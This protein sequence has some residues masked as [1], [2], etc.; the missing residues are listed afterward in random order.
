MKRK[1]KISFS[2]L[3]TNFNNGK[4]IKDAIQS[5]IDQIY[6]DWELIIVDDCSTDNSI[7]VIDQYSNNDKIKVIQHK[8]NLGYA[9]SLITAIE[10]ASNK[11][12]GILD[13][14]DKLHE[15]ALEIIYKIYQ[16]IPKYGFVYTKMWNCNSSL[17]PYNIPSWI[18]PVIPEKSD[19]F[20]H[21]ISHFRT[22]RKKDY[23][24]TSGFDPKQKKAVDQDIIYKLEEVTQF[25]FI[26]KSL[27]YYRHH[28]SG[29]SQGKSSFQARIYHYIAKCKAYKR[30]LN[31]NIPNVIL[32]D[33]YL[34][35]YK[36]TFHNMIKFLKYFYNFLKLNKKM[37]KISSFFLDFF[38]F[39]KFN[40]KKNLVK[41]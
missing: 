14:D 19:I 8:K 21:R 11:I 40:I 41:V 32:K 30:R 18:G 33:L 9:S 12:I 1:N 20:N 17:Q 4:Y 25:K 27:Y 26:D 39:D 35:Y 7:A 28:E 37:N 16:D 10:N 5:V 15:E 13:S 34:E 24:K 22:F 3:M 31:S 38:T 23:L 36:I 2:I 29:I 6:L